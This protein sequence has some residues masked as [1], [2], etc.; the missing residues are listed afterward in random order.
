MAEVMPLI[1][2]SLR[3][4]K[5]RRIYDTNKEITMNKMSVWTTVKNAWPR[6]LLC[7]CLT[8]SQKA[9]GRNR[10][11]LSQHLRTDGSRQTQATNTSSVLILSGVRSPKGICRHRHKFFNMN[12]QVLAILLHGHR[13]P[14]CPRPN[15]PPSRWD[16][17]KL[18]GN[19]L[20]SSSSQSLVSGELSAKSWKPRI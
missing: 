19:T 6:V 9:T 13:G 2:I 18:L 1:L 15:I 20:F 14:S 5:G 16:W 4:A 12:A 7:F 11:R 17:S 8:S 10:G 3:S